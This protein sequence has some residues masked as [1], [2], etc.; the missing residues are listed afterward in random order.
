MVQRFF[1]ENEHAHQKLNLQLFL[2]DLLFQRRDLRLPLLRVLRS[3]GGCPRRRLRGCLSL[4]SFRWVGSSN[5]SNAISSS[6]RAGVFFTGVPWT[7]PV[8]GMVGHPPKGAIYATAAT[9]SYA[10]AGLAADKM[11]AALK[12]KIAAA[13]DSSPVTIVRVPARRY[14]PVDN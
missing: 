14:K 10:A 5:T 7:S 4:R 12:D 3:F 6:V 2:F 8:L 13:S 1:I 9:N 11:F